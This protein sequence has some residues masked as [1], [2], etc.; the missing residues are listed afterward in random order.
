MLHFRYSAAEEHFFSH[1][2]LAHHKEKCISEFGEQRRANLEVPEESCLNCDGCRGE[3][4]E[5]LIFLQRS[6]DIGTRV[7]LDLAVVVKY[8]G[9]KGV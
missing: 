9:G 8:L 5:L 3:P 1:S 7:C 2:S 6:S 4:P